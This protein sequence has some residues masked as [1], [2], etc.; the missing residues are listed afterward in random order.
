MLDRGEDLAPTP[1]AWV[2]LEWV[3]MEDGGA[4]YA[5]ENLISACKPCHSRA[6]MAERAVRSRGNA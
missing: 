3:A 1:E 5:I 6:T 4:E 2:S